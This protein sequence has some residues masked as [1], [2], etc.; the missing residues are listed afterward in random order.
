MEKSDLKTFE[1]IDNG[2]SAIYEE[3]ERLSRE[4]FID[5]ARRKTIRKQLFF[6]P[7]IY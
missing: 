4:N 2:F 1:N 6:F 7:L 3:Y 5:I